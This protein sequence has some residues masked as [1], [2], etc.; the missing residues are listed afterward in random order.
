M[1]PLTSEIDS[2]VRVRALW[3][4]CQNAKSL[5]E[6]YLSVPA[7]ILVVHSVSFVAHI[8]YGNLTLTRM[9]LLEHRDWDFATARKTVDYP[10]LTDRLSQHFEAVHRHWCSKRQVPEDEKGPFWRLAERVR[11]AKGWY[12]SKVSPGPSTSP[13]LWEEPLGVDGFEDAAWLT[14]LDGAL[15]GGFLPTET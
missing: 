2:E 14:L 15:V 4:C 1:E 3:A 7:D 6:L 11:W 12:L 5:M 8:G 9:L 13:T 10:T